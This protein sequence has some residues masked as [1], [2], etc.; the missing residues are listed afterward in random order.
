[1][2]EHGCIH[3]SN[4]K[5]AKGTQ[6]YKVIYAYFV[7]CTSTEARKR[8]AFSCYCYICRCLGPRLHSCL[9][10]IFFGCFVSGHIQEHAKSKKHFLAVELTYGMVMCFQCG[11]YIYDR[12]LTDIANER[13]AKASKALGLPISYRSWEPSAN[14]IEL[15]RLHPRRRRVIENSTIGLRGLINLGNTCFMNCIVQ[16]LTHTPLLRD[17]FLAD[18]HQCQFRDQPGSCL[19]CEVSRLFQEFY[20]G[21]KAPLI[22]HRLLHMIWTHAHHLAGYEQQD[23]HEFFIATLNVLHRHCKGSSAHTHSSPEHCNCIIDQIF[24]G[25]LQSDVVCQACNGVSTTIDPFWDISLDLA[26]DIPTSSSESNDS[27]QKSSESSQ[28][29]N[30]QE[31]TSLIDCLTRFTRPEHLG[32]SAKIKC[33]NCQSYQESTKQLT[34]KKLPVV[35]SFHLKRF[36]HSSRFHKISTYVAFPEH[37]DMTPF[38]SH[39]RN[40]NN[41]HCGNTFNL[42]PDNRYSLFA[43]INHLGTLDGGHYTAFI[44]Q[45]QNHWFKCDDHLITKA[46]IQEVLDSEGYLLFYHKQFLEYE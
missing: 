11:D 10:C 20:S 8:K 33:S 22:L 21:N 23:A 42:L 6:P 12:E 26:T 1:M 43:V 44:R 7:A 41:G 40:M 13:D 9:H 27:G 29:S 35:A 38:M 14:E 37:L 25:G 28:K 2:S 16:A 32:S 17:F 45:Q 31:P 30:E 39:Y 18:K 19:V 4:F 3:L 24:T 46:N 15:L 36:K 5:A 34:M